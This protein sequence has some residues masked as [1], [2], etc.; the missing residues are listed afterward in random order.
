MKMQASSTFLLAEEPQPA[1]MSMSQD[2]GFHALP[3]VLLPS[4]LA[5][6]QTKGR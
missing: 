1:K 6:M 5:G 2:R 4:Y 3:P